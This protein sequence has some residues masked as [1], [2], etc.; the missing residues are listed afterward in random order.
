MR[1]SPLDLFE[2]PAL[3]AS[4]QLKNIFNP[5][6]FCGI[7]KKKRDIPLNIRK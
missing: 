5:F 7:E 4:C 6:C 3:T 2:Q 1:T